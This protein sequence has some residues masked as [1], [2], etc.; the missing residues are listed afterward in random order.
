MNDPNT[1]PPANGPVTTTSPDDARTFVARRL[2]AERLVVLAWPRAIL[3][4]LAHPLVAAGVAEHS[5]FR[6]GPTAAAARLRATVHAMR[7]L[8]FG[9]PE[10]HH[11]TLDTIREIHRR[12][13]GHL[14]VAT[15][16]FAVG[17][18]YSAE[19]PAL[20]LW[21]HATLLDSVPLIHAQVVGPLRAEER[22]RYCAE[23][24]AVAVALGARDEE[25]PRT[26]SALNA[27]LTQMYASGSIAVGAAA[28]ELAS[29]V[30]RPPLSS[31]IAPITGLNRL[32][33]IGTL[34]PHVREQYGIVWSERDE[35]RLASAFRMLA[36]VR[37]RLPDR[38]AYWP[39]A[40][41][42]R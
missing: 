19:D 23:S 34:P 6:G 16:R 22:D 36:A 26:W 13:H 11:R 35:R 33:T 24:A 29:A 28:R 25:V 37:R 2:N 21:V 32:V 30:L 42:K 10:D 27:Y 3:L 38:V 40:R 9:T 5:S 12:V 17:T 18:R 41:L 20:L 31:L 7:A 14:T 4:Q 1:A 39:E 8:T 15:G